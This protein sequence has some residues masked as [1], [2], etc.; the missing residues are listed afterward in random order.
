[1][2][3]SELQKRALEIQELYDAKQLKNGDPQ[4]TRLQLVQGLAGDVGDL[5]KIAMAKE[6]LR[7]MDNVDEKLSQEL[8]D[9]LWVTLVLAKKYN[10]DIENDFLKAMDILEKRIQE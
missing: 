3:F 6:G 8:S 2:N 4:W 9:C 10:I 7:K 5:Q 1:M